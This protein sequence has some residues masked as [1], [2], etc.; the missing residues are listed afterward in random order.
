MGG[1]GE[2]GAGMGGGGWAGVESHADNDLI[3]ILV[4]AGDGSTT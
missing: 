3:M 4:A 1:G 2:E